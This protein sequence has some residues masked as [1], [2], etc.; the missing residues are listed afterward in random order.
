MMTNKDIFKIWAPF[1]KMWIDWVRPV[2]FVAI[3]S[4]V[5]KFQPSDF[6]LP[7]ISALKMNSDTAIIIDLPDT[8]SVEAGI[9]LARKGYRP[10]PIYN[11]T[12]E[13]NGA[14]ATTDN[15]SVLDALVWGAIM[16]KSIGISDDAPPAFLTDTNR[17]QRYK[18]DCSVFDNSWDVYHQDLPTEEYFIEHGITK[19]IVISNK[20]SKDLKKI[21][22]E[23]SK[24]KLEIWWS[25]GYDAIKCIRK[26]RK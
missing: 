10:V 25:D 13:Q 1:G 18:I 26:G 22:A 9:Q 6:S 11:G 21:F 4:S 7:Y 3:D 17:L 8:Q 5:K 12:I 16:L 20:L 15:H 19:I 2:S 24:K 23:H 14:R